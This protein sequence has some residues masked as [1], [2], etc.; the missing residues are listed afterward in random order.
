AEQH[1][2]QQR[3]DSNRDQC[4][5]S[6]EYISSAERRSPRASRAT[7][8]NVTAFN[9]AIA[10]PAA[11][12]REAPVASGKRAGIPEYRAEAAPIQAGKARSCVSPRSPPVAPEPK[13][14]QR[15]CSF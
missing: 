3:Q 4:G 2:H 6:H 15:I 5:G 13:Q 11:A 14:L 10:S 8:H 9:V 7:C 1:E 12:T